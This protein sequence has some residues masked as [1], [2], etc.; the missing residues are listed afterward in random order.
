MSIPKVN[1]QI[2]Q[3]FLKS[4][5][6]SHLPYWEVIVQ[7]YENNKVDDVIFLQNAEAILAGKAY[8]L[9]KEGEAVTNINEMG[10]GALSFNTLKECGCHVLGRRENH[11]FR[12]LYENLVVE[13]VN[14][15]RNQR[16]IRIS[17]FA[18]GLLFGEYVLLTKIIN[19]FTGS[20]VETIVF[21]CIDTCYE[22][23]W[24]QCQAVKNNA[25]GAVIWREDL[26]HAIP[27]FVGLIKKTLDYFQDNF[28]IK[29]RFFSRKKCLLQHLFENNTKSHILIGADRGATDEDVEELSKELKCFSIF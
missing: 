19:N 3:C 14:Q 11:N 16:I 26:E 5:E 25:I 7:K 10:K 12:D 24:D 9:L 28:K 2:N 27:E 22:A 29:L 18:T 21:N 6:F 17:A 20:A 15:Y 1:P 8:Q 13:Y 4:K 23:Y